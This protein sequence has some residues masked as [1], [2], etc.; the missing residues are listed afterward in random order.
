MP[1]PD[2]AFQKIR[3][4]MKRAPLLVQRCTVLDLRELE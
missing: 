3:F 1:A 4:K 2:V